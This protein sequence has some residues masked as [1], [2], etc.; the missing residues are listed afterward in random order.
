MVGYKGVNCV[1][2]MRTVTT[3]TK[4]CTTHHFACDCREAW[5]RDFVQQAKYANIEACYICTVKV[6]DRC[7]VQ[8]MR[9]KIREYDKTMKGL[10]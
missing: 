8:K 2:Y 6:C 5:F 10:V 3:M 9:E 4:P 1:Y 7:H